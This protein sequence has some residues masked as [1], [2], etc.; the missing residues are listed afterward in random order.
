[1]DSGD[2]LVDQHEKEK[3]IFVTGT[4]TEIG[5]T[6]IAGGL[7]AILKQAGVNVGVMKPISTGDMT[8]ANYLKHAA[9]VDDP[10]DMINPI[11]LRNPLAPSVSAKIEDRHVDIFEIGKAHTELQKKYD[12]LIIEGVGG[13]AVPINDD[14]QVVD[15]IKYLT[16]P[17]IIVANAGLGTINHTILTVEYA[18]QHKVSILGIVLNMFQ[19][20]KASLPELTNPKEI[21]R[22]TQIPVLGVI[23]FN[24]QIDKPNPDADYLADFLRKHMQ[25][26]LLNLGN[27]I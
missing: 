23:P 10:L 3:G 9:Q 8:D 13:I 7:A 15:L 5:K 11:S 6:V 19:S 26:E 17:I 22:A 14:K 25:L 27:I 18:R 4:D 12:Y 24:E 2:V 1:M 16:L 20:E 21:E